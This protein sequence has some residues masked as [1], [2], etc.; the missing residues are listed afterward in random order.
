MSIAQAISPLYLRV[1]AN[2]LV[3]SLITTVITLVVSFPLAWMI[4][5]ASGVRRLL[6]ILLVLV[7]FLTS[8]LVRT[9]SWVVILG[10]NG[11]INSA[12]QALGLTDQPREMLFTTGA[13]VI[14]LVHVTIP[15]MVF[16]LVTVM[17][18]V[19]TRTLL[20]ARSLGAGSA[21]AFLRVIV[22]L[23]IPGIR[24]GAILVFLF[25]MATFIAPAVLGGK[26]QTMIA[27][28]IQSQIEN[29]YNWSLAASLGLVLAVIAL[30][31]VGL[32]GLLTRWLTPWQN[33]RPGTRTMSPSATSVP[34]TVLREQLTTRHRIPPAIR[35]VARAASSVGRHTYLPLVTIFMLLPLV[36]LFPVAFSDGDTIV[37]PP[38]TYSL[39]WFESIVTNPD[40]VNAAGTSLR[41]GG[42]VA[43][44]ATALAVL[45]VLGLGRSRNPLT[46]VIESIA[47]APLSVP[48]VVFAVGAYLAYAELFRLTGR[49]IRL[50]D[51]EIGIMIA[52]TAL[53][54]PFAFV[55]VSAAYV[56]VDATLER[57]AASLGASPRRILGRITLPLMAPG[58]LASLLLCFLHSFDESVV[59][60][61]LS[62]LRVTTLPRLLW[63]GIRFGTSPDVAAVSALLLLLTCITVAL[64]GVL[65]AWRQRQLKRTDFGL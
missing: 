14:A 15:L 35:R 32:I 56:G 25:S 47:M 2:T 20:V 11:V 41:I 63:D 60:L 44:V 36:V 58:L 57:S 34:S 3:I 54:V 55:L 43:V 13:V 12:L 29:G 10:R 62:G 51:S 18:R 46:G 61:F 65:L 23:S 50:T 52:H 39:R 27:Q 28:V 37:F 1:A 26:D 8:V 42:V 30:I 31:V 21:M 24:S 59:S 5:R 64:I 7:P 22:P 49:A 40:W 53:T 19:D 4:S 48:T 17:Q 6:L 38:R 9:F 16:S 33:A 45:L